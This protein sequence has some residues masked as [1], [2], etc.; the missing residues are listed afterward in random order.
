MRS[1]SIIIIAAED[2]GREARP[3]FSELDDE[4]EEEAADD[5]EG[6]GSLCLERPLVCGCC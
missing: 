5:D 1:C 6:N 3:R 4:E 2:S